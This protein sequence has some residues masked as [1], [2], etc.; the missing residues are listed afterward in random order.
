MSILAAHL[1]ARPGGG[2][3]Y[4]PNS[5]ISGRGGGAPMPNRCADSALAKYIAN[6]CRVLLGGPLDRVMALDVRL[7]ALP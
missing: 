7:G 5:P 3:G 1:K 2:L 4:P 6:E